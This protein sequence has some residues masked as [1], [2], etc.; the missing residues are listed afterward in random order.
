MFSSGQ[1]SSIKWK[2]GQANK[3]NLVFG[4]PDYNTRADFSLIERTHTMN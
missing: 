3:Q 2:F 1:K 4:S